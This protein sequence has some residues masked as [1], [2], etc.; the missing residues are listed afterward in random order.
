MSATHL[1]S[2]RTHA[3]PLGRRHPLRGVLVVALT[4]GLG[5]TLLP[6]GAS[7][8][9]GAPGSV[10]GMVFR[11][12][13][14]N[15]VFNDAST[16]PVPD[17]GLFDTP[18]EGVTVTAY[19]A[20]DVAVGTDTTDSTGGYSIAPAVSDG[21]AVRIEFTG[22]PTGFYESFSGP[23]NGT[24][25]Q[26]AEVG[27]ENIDFALHTLEDYSLGTSTPIVT[28][29]Q[30]NGPGTGSTAAALTAV[31]PK[32]AV[33]TASVAA[34]GVD[35]LATIGEVGAVSSLAVERLDATSYNVYAA[36]VLKRH[37]GFGPQGIAGLYRIEVEVEPDGDVVRTAFNAY[38]LSSSTALGAGS[39]GTVARDLVDRGAG[40][41]IDAAAFAAA[42]TAGI[43][44]IEYR[45]GILYVVNLSDRAIYGFDTTQFGAAATDVD[46]APLEIDAAALGLGV[47]ERPWA[48][49]AYGDT[50]YVGV[51]DT[52]DM[53][54]G[55]RV[56]AAPIATPAAFTT[57]LQIPLGYTRGVVWSNA[58]VAETD[59]QAQWHA[60]RNS[61]DTAFWNDADTD[62]S[63]FAWAQPIL[64]DLA[65]DDSGNLVIALADRFGLQG[66][67]DN[68]WPDVLTN[69]SHTNATSVPVGDVLFAG[70]QAGDFALEADGVV[71]ARSGT[72]D[73][74]LT[75]SLGSPQDAGQLARAAQ[76]GPGGREFFE[77]SVTWNGFGGIWG[78]RSVH[79]ETTLGS[80]AIIPGTGRVTA[81]SYDPASSYFTGGNRWMSLTD[82]ESLEGFDQYD[83]SQN[84]Y[85][86]KSGGL[87]GLATLAADAPIQI[88]NRVWLDEDRDG[89]QDAGE[90][91]V[92]DIT[93]NLYQG[94][95]LLGTTVTDADGEY[96]FSSLTV[97]GLGADGTYTVE[98]VKPTS[99]TVTLS[100]GTTTLTAN[101]LTFSP[102]TVGSAPTIDSDP[103]VTTGTASVTTG[104]LGENDHSIDAGLSRKTYAIGD[105]VWIDADRDGLQDASEAPLPGVTVRLFD[106]TD[107]ELAS[108]TTDTNGL[109][110]FDDLLAGQYRV[111]FELPTGYT[112]TAR[113]ALDGGSPA[114]ADDSDA[115]PAAAG[116]LPAG[117]TDLFVLDAD[118]L[119]L[120][121]T[122]PLQTISA[123]DGI[124]P[125]WDAGVVADP[126][127][128]PFPLASTGTTI[129][130]LS[131]VAAAAI[132]L[133]GVGIV[134]I[135]RRFRPGR[136]EHRA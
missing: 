133:L 80:L 71:S 87:G 38:D 117:S 42:G 17:D 125:T 136:A 34:A 112:F 97:A 22:Y 25:V 59:P 45:D 19:D 41:T 134:A 85:F 75:R 106:A 72:S 103:D 130:W 52:V 27:D 2:S 21:T 81:T 3:A 15:G 89:I 73:V 60:W 6:L 12:F 13:N 126:D 69:G 77:D 67:R 7:P 44:G 110:L 11:D 68:L 90:L 10:S 105:Y 101:E 78:E 4:L 57:E 33:R 23:G 115:Y 127:L 121:T 64:T 29:L 119:A 14:Q 37:A 94:A 16:R 109:Y 99:G 96:V 122:Y 83:A 131:I 47:N 32:D 107:T 76:Q 61:G 116:A 95:T 129:P 50:L 55:A 31:M 48:V 135:A 35:T 70:L 86:G 26:F 88:G 36:A 46:P 92:R 58:T 62:F 20:A 100:D 79:D 118:S 39:F 91:G 40:T 82:G 111:E 28:A 53:A 5:A 124:D 63:F 1:A 43:G 56:I 108:T 54:Q 74:T 18:L 65:F 120:T 30:T 9:V 113:N 93:V 114:T 49:R 132:T 123:T 128:P 98:F 84:Q 24:S 51:T 104:S 102:A 66:G 8:A